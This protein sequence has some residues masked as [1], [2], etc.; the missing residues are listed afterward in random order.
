MDNEFDRIV[1]EYRTGLRAETREDLR[2]PPEPAVAHSAPI[3]PSQEAPA[4]AEPPV[5]GDS[6]SATNNTPESTEQINLPLSTSAILNTLIE[7]QTVLVSVKFLKNLIG[8]STPKVVTRF[9]ER[10]HTA[11]TAAPT[12][13]TPTSSNYRGRVAGQFKVRDFR[14]TGRNWNDSMNAVYA[15]CRQHPDGVTVRETSDGLNMPLS[16]AHNCLRKLL[17]K[18]AL[19]W[20]RGDR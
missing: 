2:L 14:L 4:H 3:A 13:P 5:V 7:G 1:E 17:K 9:R 6:G 16:T 18:Q 8:T 11:P 10:V 19:R 15:F 20:V 12:Q